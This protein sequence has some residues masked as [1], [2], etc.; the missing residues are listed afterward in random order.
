M[1]Q[2]LESAE[3]VP[4]CRPIWIS[5]WETHA[6][7][8]ILYLGNSKIRYRKRYDVDPK[9]YKDSYFG[10]S[11]VNQ[12]NGEWT[13]KLAHQI[14]TTHSSI[15]AFL[16]VSLQKS[17]GGCVNI[18]L[19]NMALRKIHNW[20][21]RPCSLFIAM[22]TTCYKY[23]VS[24]GSMTAHGFIPSPAQWPPSLECNKIFPHKI[25]ASSNQ[26]L[27]ISQ[28]RRLIYRYRDP[29]SQCRTV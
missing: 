6:S 23:T 3:G 28:R 20:L 25:V 13:S 16:V 29:R 18:L 7:M 2:L 26:R 17:S 4:H 10:W 5:L 9:S 15:Q 19:F 12:C 11:S 1:V 22:T 8:N 27:P 14:D 21:W 24:W